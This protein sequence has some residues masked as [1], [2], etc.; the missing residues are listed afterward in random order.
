MKIKYGEVQFLAKWLLQNLSLA[1]KSNRMR[2]RFVEILGIKANELRKYYLQLLQEHC[3]LD[4]QG[5]PKTVT[6]ENDQTTYDVIDP[7]A[8]ERDLRELL[9]ETFT[10]ELNDE[11]KE[12]LLSIR[13][14]LIDCPTPWSGDQA[15]EHE[16][17][18]KLFDQ[19]RD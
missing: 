19:I 15:L 17:V 12:M 6:V 3:Y 16:M 9:E 11:N 13:Q 14:S 8:F 10:L 4:D 5:V 7:T 2:I 18:A 1:G